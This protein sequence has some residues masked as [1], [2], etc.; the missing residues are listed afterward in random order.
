[1]RVPRSGDTMTVSCAGDTGST[2]LLPATRES[3]HDGGFRRLEMRDPDSNRGHH[4]FQS[5]WPAAQVM[6]I[7]R[8][9]RPFRRS[10]ARPDFLA[11]GGRFSDVTADERP[12]RPFRRG[13]QGRGTPARANRWW[14]S[15]YGC[16]WPAVTAGPG[17]PACGEA[18]DRRTRARGRDFEVGSQR[19]VELG[20]DTTRSAKL[21]CELSADGDPV[22]ERPAVDGLND[23]ELLLDWVAAVQAGR[24]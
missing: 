20:S 3:S 21:G 10:R 1:V 16:T 24:G 18:D 8:R 5:R 12:R 14:L 19:K 6:A 17:G 9:F 7:C 4:D 22:L 2:K 11:T 15:P 13:A 23:R